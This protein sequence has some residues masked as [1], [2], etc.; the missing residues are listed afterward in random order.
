MFIVRIK[1]YVRPEKEF[2]FTQTLLSMIEPTK[3]E[4]GCLSYAVF[5][6]LEDSH[7]YNLLAEWKTRKDLSRHLETTRFGVLLGLKSLLAE[8]SHIRIY[9]I[10]VTEGIELVKQIRE[11][12]Q[13]AAKSRKIF[14]DM[15]KQ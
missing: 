1:W 7:C 8:P 13:A 10:K 14:N 9:S 12:R 11:K 5:S 4:P 2:E 3:R 15:D 6:N